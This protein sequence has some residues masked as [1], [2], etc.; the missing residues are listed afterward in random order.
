[1]PRG[2]VRQCLAALVGLALSFAL[3]ASLAR[4]GGRYF[5]CEAM[6]LL[7]TDPC[8]AAPAA[9]DGR[10]TSEDCLDQ[11]RPDCCE[12]FTLRALP[13]GATRAPTNVPP[14]AVVALL[15]AVAAI[16]TA[17][18]PLAHHVPATWRAPPRPP[19]KLRAHAHNQVFLT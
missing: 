13:D 16:E 2:L 15:P 18:E 9:S 7:P 3:V 14:A 4:P 11:T 6:G 19:G 10:S 17:P 1:V 8:R 12:V 5:Y